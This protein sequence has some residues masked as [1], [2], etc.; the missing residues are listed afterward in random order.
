MRTITVHEL[1]SKL[2]AKDNF[3]FLD[4][5]EPGEYE[6]ANLGA[7]LLPLGAIANA[8]I[9]DIEDWK[10][11]EVIIHCRSGMRSAQA[12]MV[13]ETMGFTNTVNVMGGILAYSAEFGLP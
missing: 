2:D 8:Q 4:V 13:L 9:D 12:C 6:Q 3:K 11:E 5:R 7:V 10:N 1:K